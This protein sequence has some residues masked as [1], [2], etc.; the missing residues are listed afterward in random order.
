MPFV[1]SA[2]TFGY[3]RKS[4]VLT[5]LDLKLP[6]GRTVLLGPNGAGKSTL[7]GLA[8]SV[9]RPDNGQVLYGQLRSS[10][11]KDRAAYRARV[12]W[13]PQDIKPV[14]GLTVREQVAYVGWLKGL[15]RAEAWDR[16]AAALARVRL[17]PLGERPSHALSGG[18]LRRLGLAQTLVHKADVVLMDE[19]TAGLDPTQRK[20]FRDL[21]TEVSANAHIIVSTHQ[22]EDL[23]DIYE[24]VVVFDA[25]QPRFMGS[26]PD[27]LSTV[28]ALRLPTEQR[29]E[30]AYAA[31]VGREA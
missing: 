28:T 27:F 16:S 24:N 26:V 15:P 10:R 21:I 20:V 6:E 17:E 22:T 23:T 19:P 18:Q 4:P 2:C 25:G 5:E 9:L 31:F 1:F 29:A 8:S 13:M 3:Q 14:P 12:G 30:A 11:G 7:L